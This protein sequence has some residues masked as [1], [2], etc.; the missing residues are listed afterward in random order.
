MSSNLTG[1]TNGDFD[2]V[3]TDQLFVNGVEITQ[4]GGGGGGGTYVLPL[5]ANGT[6][7]GV[8]VGYSQND[9][10]YPIEL[11]D[12]KMYVN[13]PWENTQLSL[14]GSDGIDVTNGDELS[15]K[16]DSANSDSTTT[17][18][19][20]GGIPAGTAFSELKSL[21]LPALIDK[22][23][24]PVLIPIKTTASTISSFSNLPSVVRF[25][26]V[27][28]TNV[29]FSINLGG[30]S[31]QNGDT[32]NQNNNDYLGE[33]TSGNIALFGQTADS[34]TINSSAR[35]ID[36]Y[37]HSGFTF[38]PI[39]STQITRTYTSIF[40]FN[41][42]TYTLVDS[43]G[44]SF[45]DS[46]VPLPAIAQTIGTS[47]AYRTTIKSTVAV[48]EFQKGTSSGNFESANLSN[49]PESFTFSQDFTETSSI[50]HAIYIPSVY[51]QPNSYK[52]QKL[53]TISNNYE[54]L[55]SSQFDIT[56]VSIDVGN[57]TGVSY[58]KRAYNGILASSGDYK[59][60]RL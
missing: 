17:I 29:T 7:G 31:Y 34:L 44:N 8:Q 4:N 53:N 27:Y 5:A 47:G 39:F 32:I 26:D 24:N 51:L 46:S 41:V 52:I 12:E 22:M 9:K 25:G 57:L 16:F 23:F 37:S 3:T 13:V 58:Q 28:N 10:N 6:R 33:I 18:Y 50:R 56:T 48:Y 60:V 59:L 35:S 11:D 42:A 36:A 1:L 19:D 43:N 21:S 2:V 40:T 38:S 20:L 30:I 54:D 14:T 15:T 49:N 55:A 45:T